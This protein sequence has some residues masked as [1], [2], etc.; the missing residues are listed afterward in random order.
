MTLLSVEP[1]NVQYF[2]VMSLDPY[3]VDVIIPHAHHLQP[4]R[5]GRAAIAATRV[6]VDGERPN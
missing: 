2:W 4:G 6:A 3:L 5:R 1:W